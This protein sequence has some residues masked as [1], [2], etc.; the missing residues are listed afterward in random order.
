MFLRI[1]FSTL[2]LNLKKLKFLNNIVEKKFKT[3][4]IDILFI[5]SK[6][7]NKKQ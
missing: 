3:T 6:K 2:Y 7:I 5:R 1:T 4:I